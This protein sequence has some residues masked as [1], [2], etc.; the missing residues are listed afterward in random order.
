MLCMVGPLL[1]EG[2]PDTRERNKVER[3]RREAR[4]D[5]TNEG[6]NKRETRSTVLEESETRER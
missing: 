4:E 6:E 5:E 2:N 1:L 3:E